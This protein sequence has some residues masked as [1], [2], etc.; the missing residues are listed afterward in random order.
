MSATIVTERPAEAPPSP[1]PAASVAVAPP[2]PVRRAEGIREPGWRVRI[3]VLWIVVAVSMSAVMLLTVVEPGVIAAAMAGKTPEGTDFTP[4]ITVLFALCWLVPLAMAVL[5][6]TLRA[7]I[8]RPVNLVMGLVAAVWW[9]LE[10]TEGE[11]FRAA[12][13]MATAASIA[14]LLIAW[15]AWRWPRPSLTTPTPTG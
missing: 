2:A 10:F 6:V 5:T 14:G 13:L 11:G 15:H 9:L 12:L 3:A 4:A 8:N 7:G 1:P